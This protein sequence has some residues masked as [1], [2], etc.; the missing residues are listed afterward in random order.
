ML[1]FILRVYTNTYIDVFSNLGLHVRLIH[2]A[3]TKTY[4]NFKFGV[5]P[6]NHAA[7]LYYYKKTLNLTAAFNDY[8]N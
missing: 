8:S 4:W 6:Q 2:H 1:G 3:L 7:E 5:G